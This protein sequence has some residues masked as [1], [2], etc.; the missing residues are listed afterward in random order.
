MRNLDAVRA[1]LIVFGD[2]SPH[3]VNMDRYRTQECQQIGHSLCHLDSQQAKGGKQYPHRRNEEHALTGSGKERGRYGSSN[4]LLHHVA[5][6]N[7]ALG[8][9]TDALE[10]QCRRTAGDD[11]RIVTEYLD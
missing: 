3:D 11:R 1:V 5:H 9:E 4:G 6:Y 7:P 8:R 2:K 10:P